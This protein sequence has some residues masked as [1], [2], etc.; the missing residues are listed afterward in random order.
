MS[1]WRGRH[2]LRLLGRA[3][4]DYVSIRLS[5][6]G[7]QPTLHRDPGTVGSVA[8]DVTGRASGLEVVNTRFLD[9]N[10]PREFWLVRSG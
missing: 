3:Y 8:S 6:S 2:P 7:P 9:F 5:T 4:V 1:A 10:Y